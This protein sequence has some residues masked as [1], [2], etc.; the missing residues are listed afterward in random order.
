MYTLQLVC[1]M[2]NLDEPDI[3]NEAFT[4]SDLETIVSLDL[5]SFIPPQLPTY[6]PPKV[7]WEDEL[8]EELLLPGLQMVVGA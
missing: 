6:L 1:A 8:I 5:E 7:A 4:A 3:L 2:I